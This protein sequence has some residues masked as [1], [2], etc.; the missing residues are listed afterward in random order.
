MGVGELL[1]G[2][3]R[4]FRAHLADFWIVG[5][6]CQAPVVMV[7]FPAPLAATAVSFLS[8]GLQVVAVLWLAARAILGE[9]LDRM[10][11]LGFAIRGVIPYFIGVVIL[12]L[13]G[14]VAFVP[15][16]IVAGV[17]GEAASIAL[18]LGLFPIA[19]FVWVR[20]HPWRQVLLLEREWSFV[21]RSFRLTNGSFWRIFAVTVLGLILV[22]IPAAIAQVSTL[23]ATED[24]EQL[25]GDAIVS[26]PSAILVGALVSALIQPFGIILSTL[27]YYEL[28][29]R[30]E[31]YDMDLEA[32][33]FEAALQHEPRA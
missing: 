26:P 14:L 30:S 3:F 21:P 31:G 29:V 33:A 7:A 32:D 2:A 9:P 8:Y 23:W 6:I 13:A 15:V 10:A 25:T 1:D 17:A 24:L 22:G 19:L 28:R 18:S 12:M 5:L 4:I 11:S 16:A 27:L 20:L